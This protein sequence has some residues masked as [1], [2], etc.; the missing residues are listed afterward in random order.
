MVTC[1]V[2]HDHTFPQASCGGN[3]P[4]GEAKRKDEMGGKGRRDGSTGGGVE[5]RNGEGETA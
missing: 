4:S 3:N 1:K 2:E 5:G